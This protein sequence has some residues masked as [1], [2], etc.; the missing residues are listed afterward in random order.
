M[1]NTRAFKKISEQD[2]NI[3][4]FKVYKSWRYEST[5]SLDN[6]GIDRLSA[7]KPNHSMYAGAKVTLDTWQT[8]NDSSSLYINSVNDKEASLIWYSLNHLYY[9]R[10]SIPFETFGYSDPAVIE[11]TIFDEASVISIPQKQFGESIKPGSVKLHLQNSQLNSNSMSLYDD[12]KGNLIDSALSSSIS[13]EI[14]YLGFNAMTYSDFWVNDPATVWN[15]LDESNV[16][17]E[18]QNDTTIQALNVTGKNIYIANSEQVHD[19]FGKYTTNPYGNSAMFKSNAY[20]RIPNN[21]SLNFK[22]SEDFAIGMWIGHDN[23]IG[24]NPLV[25]VLSKRTTGKQNVR[26]KKGVYNYIDVNFPI[27][28]Y[29]YDVR[30]ISGSILECRQSNGSEVTSITGSL[31]SNN[32]NHIL[33]QK[34]G[35]NFELYLNG[36]LAESKPIRTENYHNEADIFIGSLGLN[37]DGSVNQG[38]VGSIDEFLIFSKGL[39]NTEI[40]QLSYTGSMDLMTSNTNAVGNVFYEQGM[41]V[42]SDPRPK[43]GTSTYRMFDDKL[44]NYKTGVQ[45]PN[46]LSKFLLEFNSTVTLYEHEYIC[47]ANEDEFNF[48]MNDTI[49]LD[50]NENSDITK[51]IVTN[52]HFSPY[53][54]TVGLYDQYGR[55]LAIGKLGTPIKKRNDVELNIIV[56]FDM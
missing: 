5:S 33:L 24:A 11:R 44:F 36:N 53:I 50:N 17:S 30:V 47:K 46:Y 8:A 41:I 7:I 18:I 16:L 55:L 19:L 48:T 56:K 10:A 51:S 35:S 23:T 54:T 42:I 12:G 31:L 3:T 45:R 38:F 29:P 34:T 39:T 22:R 27:S 32:L 20:I 4:P 37:N 1:S 25:T 52:K 49:R 14:L 28:Q 2:K 13:N 43:Y 15:N 21:E 6:S 40:L 9:K 26:S